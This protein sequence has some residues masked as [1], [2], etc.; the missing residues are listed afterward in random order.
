MAAD[1]PLLG[2]DLVRLACSAGQ[3]EIA[4]GVTLAVEGIAASNAIESYTA[5]AL[6]CRGLLDSDLAKMT[7]AVETYARASRNVETALT[8][9]EAAGIA[10]EDGEREAAREL[11]ERAWDIFTHLD[12]VRCLARV[13]ARYR[14]LGIRRGVRGPRRRPAWGWGSLTPT[15]TEVA[16]LVAEGLSNPQIAERLFIS[17]R[18]VQTH[19]SH[20]FAKL[21]IAS[22]AQLAVQVIEHRRRADGH[23]HPHHQ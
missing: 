21:N 4:E 6:R 17:R 1:Y 10:I 16:E 23:P 15:E 13:D 3:R 8:C 12:A 22:R 7:R 18:T 2:P 19:V 20:A 14:Q 11:L 5:A 9:E